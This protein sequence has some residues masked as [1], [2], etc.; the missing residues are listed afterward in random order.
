MNG[1]VQEI[2]G[3]WFDEVGP[4]GWYEVDPAL[5]ARIRERFMGLWEAAGRGALDQWRIDPQGTLALMVLLDQFPRNMFRGN[6]RAFSTD[7][8]AIGIAKSAIARDVDLELE[9]EP[10]HFLRLPFCHSE[11]LEEQERGVR[12]CLLR[13]GTE[14][15]V[16]HSCAHR[17]V[18][19]RFGRFPFRNEALGRRSTKAETEWLATGA[20]RAAVAEIEDARKAVL[21]ARGQMV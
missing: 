6:P 12:Y 7:L 3:F 16:V 14:S 20:Y 17:L 11:S 13:G 15:H 21:A 18:I 4:K 9:P 2:L 5:D 19:R 10:R 1:M 8:R